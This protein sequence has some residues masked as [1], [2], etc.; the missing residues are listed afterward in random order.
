MASTTLHHQSTGITRVIL[1]AVEV[2]V[3][4][5]AVFGGIGLITDTLGMQS[6]WLS[7]TGFSSWVWPGVF[8][9]LAIAAPMTAAAI[10]E[11]SKQPWAYAISVTAGAVLIGWI[12]VQWLIIGKYFFLQPTMLAVGLLVLLLARL[13]HRGEPIRPQRY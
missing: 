10:G 3:A 8:L 11:W 9:L 12:V 7:G 2:F 5:G 4:V 6:D 1:I 13:T